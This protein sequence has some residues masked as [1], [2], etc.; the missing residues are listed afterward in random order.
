M[1]R[2]IIVFPKGNNV[3]YLSVYLTVADS[4]TLPRG[5]SK[6]AM[7]GLSVSNQFHPK[8]TITE[9]FEHE[10]KAGERSWGCPS[11]VALGELHDSTKGF[12]VND[13]CIVKAE[14][15]LKKEQDEKELKIEE[16][17][18]LVESQQE[19]T[20]VDMQS[21]EAQ[22][23]PT[24]VGIQPAKAQ[25]EPKP[26]D[27]Q[28][29]IP[30]AHL[31]ELPTMPG[32]LIHEQI[33]QVA[34]P[35]VVIE[36]QPE[37]LNL[38]EEANT[39]TVPLAPLIV[40]PPT[41]QL[42]KQPDAEAEISPSYLSQFD[43]LFGDI[44]NLLE[45]KSSNSKSLG[46]SFPRR[47]CSK[48]EISHA[49][50]TFKECLNMKLAKVIEEGRETELKNSLSIMIIGNACP[51]NMVSFT[52]KFI[53]NFEQYAGAQQDLREVQDK[54]SSID[55][56]QTTAKQL[57]SEFMPLRNQAEAVDQEIV[58]LERQ[59]SEKKA[60]KVWL[61]KSIEDLAEQASTSKQA[62]I[63]AQ[64]VMSLL[65]IKKKQAVKMVSEMEWSWEL[66][67]STIP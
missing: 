24:P 53:D 21:A 5:W 40:D 41:A 57:A 34:V 29:I 15:T 56:L 64:E 16:K 52:T 4:V 20:N 8:F 12:L 58:E 19:P 59:L 25:L 31:S 36:E 14:V 18:D 9:A 22:P 42:P 30:D 32:N 26:T 23:E 44:E 39:T 54:E 67:K 46:S 38:K 47:A 28:T 43:A 27:S 2:R 50:N 11:F 45:G 10:F 6:Y 62:L 48:E 35:S 60:K 13:T 63:D 7:V 51:D 65:R 61:R 49:K 33:T 66:L 37:Q 17:E 55:E 3:D 1:C